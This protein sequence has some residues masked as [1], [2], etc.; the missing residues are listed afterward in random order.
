[1]DN[2]EMLLLARH[3]RRL[4]TQAELDLLA[5]HRLPLTGLAGLRRYLAERDFETFLAVYFGDELTVPWSETHQ[6]VLAQVQDLRDRWVAK[7]K[8]R[9]LALAIPRGLGKT[10]L[11]SRLQPLWRFLSG[12]SPLTLLI[13][14]NSEA[15]TR[16]VRNVRICYE[17]NARLREDYPGVPGEVWTSEKL[18]NRQNGAMLIGLSRG[19][20]A[21]RGVS[22][23]NSRVTLCVLDD[24]DDDQS[25]SSAVETQQATD[26]LIKSVLPTGDNLRGT[27]SFVI[28]GTRLS[29]QSVLEYALNSSDFESTI[30]KGITRFP[31]NEE[32]VVAWERWLL[33]QAADNQA[34]SDYDGDTFWQEHLSELETNAEVIWP[35]L[36]GALLYQYLRY[37]LAHGERAFRAEVQNELD[38][39]G[40]Q[41][42][43]TYPTIDPTLVPPR[44]ECELLLS[45]DPSEGRSSRSDYAAVVE[46]LWHY[47]TRT[48]FVVWA[49]L[50]KRGYTKVISSTAERVKARGTLYDGAWCERNGLGGIFADLLQK[51]LNDDGCDLVMVGHYS[52]IPKNDRI[53]VLGELARQGRLFFIAGLPDEM[54]REWESFPTGKNDDGLDA[55]ATIPLKLRE[56]GRLDP[57]V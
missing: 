56:Q 12:T 50:E 35:Q 42:L 17:Q 6:Q 24:I 43:G 53:A 2:Q 25:V 26:W 40:S 55:V 23:G 15:A 57:L 3:A 48:L 45:V 18:V 21:I 14:N 16:L 22:T 11:L 7:Q 46:V 34:P 37:R 39:A 47:A 10:S 28:V 32:L 29:K 36:G 5:A 1:M 49:D 8:G 19:S 4:L 51:R 20:G 13:G 9:K 27:S 31:G 30:R 54:R 44:S 33:Q 41:A 52:R 38:D